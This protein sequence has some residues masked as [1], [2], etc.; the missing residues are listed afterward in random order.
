MAY[1]AGALW[2]IVI[3]RDGFRCILVL[4]A[5][6][7]ALWTM[8]RWPDHPKTSRAI[9]AGALAGIGVWTYQPLKL[10]PVLAALWLLWMWYAAPDVFRR[11]RPTIPWA[12]A[13]YFVVAAPLVVVAVVD[14][15]GYLG[16]GAGVTPFVS[17]SQ[18]PFPE[19]MLRTLGMF[20]FT[21]DPNPR[22]D[23]AELPLLGWPLFCLAALGVWRAW[24]RPQ[25]DHALLLVGL[26]VFLVPPI[27]AVEGSTP[28]F[29]RALGLAPFV[30]GFIGLGS[31]QVADLAARYG[32]N[33]QGSRGLAL[34]V[35]A[36]V[37]IGVGI[38][39]VAAYFKQQEGELYLAYRYNLVEIGKAAAA[40][41][42]ATV[43]IDDYSAFTVRFVARDH[44]PRIVAPGAVLH[45]PS[46]TYIAGD[47]TDLKRAL[48]DAVAS[49]S[50]VLAR[51]G[52]GNARA[53][54]VT[55]P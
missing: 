4:P 34:A 29:L 45:D 46:G 40:A 7:L 23:A 41:P 9:A 32:F 42:R 22:H 33:L 19:H 39:G 1:T 49:R 50:T 10:L 3:S 16:R 25:P 44:P 37:I 8:A 15:N 12:L 54:Q 36:V 38:G 43:I 51:D 6:A 48:G 55:L 18:M 26:A 5:G 52:V 53:W 14:T 28:H 31:L 20:T 13:S 47:L 27:V 35:C 21:G 2:L 11:V 24:R 30:A 17:Q